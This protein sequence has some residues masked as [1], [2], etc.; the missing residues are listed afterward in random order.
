MTSN[1]FFFFF[2]RWIFGGKKYFPKPWISLTSKI[3]K[4]KSGNQ[5]RDDNFLFSQDGIILKT[6]QKN[7]KA[8]KKTNKKNT[9][10][11]K[12][13]I[14]FTLEKLAQHIITDKL[15][16]QLAS[17]LKPALGPHS[18]NQRQI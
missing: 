12:K 7:S 6:K 14:N 13:Y 17:P 5:P 11:I 2:W 9:I 16:L 10:I 18:D 4:Q 1:E 15:S 8:K 3:P